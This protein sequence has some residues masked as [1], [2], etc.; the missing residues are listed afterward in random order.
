MHISRID[1]GREDA[2]ERTK[3]S[4]NVHYALRHDSDAVQAAG[5][6]DHSPS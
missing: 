2:T 4:V 1:R 5:V 3:G 6:G